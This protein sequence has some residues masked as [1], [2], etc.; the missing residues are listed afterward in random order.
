MEASTRMRQKAETRAT[1]LAGFVFAEVRVRRPP[2]DRPTDDERGLI[3]K[4]CNKTGNAS[5]FARDALGVN[6][7]STLTWSGQT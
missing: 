3:E 5:V 6:W 4:V 2:T 1:F 7:M